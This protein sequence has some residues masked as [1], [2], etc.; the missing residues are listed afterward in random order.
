M[1]CCTKQNELVDHVDVY[2]VDIKINIKDE[3]VQTF[4]IIYDEAEAALEVIV[5]T[6]DNN[7]NEVD[8]KGTDSDLE[9]KVD[10][11]AGVE[12]GIVPHLLRA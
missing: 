11:P 7:E 8:A 2:D 5:D 6:K 4:E 3:V 1:N 12:N 10:L 9:T